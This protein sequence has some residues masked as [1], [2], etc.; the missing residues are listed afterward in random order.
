MKK[1]LLARQSCPGFESMHCRRNYS[2][3]LEHVTMQ[4]AIKCD[5]LQKKDKE[6]QMRAT[7]F[8]THHETS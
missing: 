8:N 7:S 3:R 1:G 4:Y 2:S 6:I 5:E